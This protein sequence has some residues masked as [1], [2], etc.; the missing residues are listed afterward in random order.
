VAELDRHGY[1]LRPD[2]VF[3]V[4]HTL[5]RAGFLRGRSV[6]VGGKRRKYYET[7][8]RGLDV[9]RAASVRLQKLAAELLTPLPAPK[10]GRFGSQSER[11][12][13]DSRD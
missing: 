11:R 3:S 5:D 6:L 2:K 9:M 1:Q 4:L 8:E 12:L 10:E 13:E 7:T